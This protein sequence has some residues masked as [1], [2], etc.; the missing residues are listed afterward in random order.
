MNAVVKYGLIGGGALAG[1][2]LL[3][4]GYN[5]RGIV[6]QK[7]IDE[8]NIE[9]VKN[10]HPSIRKQA[11]NFLYDMK[12]AGYT[13][14]FYGTRTF[15]SQKKEHDKNPNAAKPG[16]SLHNYGLAF[17]VNVLKPIQLGFKQSNKEWEPVVKIAKKNGF[18]WGGTLL[19]NYS[20]GGGDKV[21]FQPKG[22]GLRGT[23]LLAMKNAGKVDKNG[24]VKLT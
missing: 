7:M 6:L 15:E 21:H 3:Y 9:T 22:L 14:L 20:S 2:G 10:L 23:E 5:F 13:I 11:Y 19:P 16:H 18:D 17:D 4:A 8:K 1:L 24:F 12:K